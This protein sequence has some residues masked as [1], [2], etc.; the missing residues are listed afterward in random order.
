MH[1]NCRVMV[2]GAGSGV[3][4]G[5]IKSLKK[6]KLPITII[7]ADISKM[8]AGLYVADEAAIIPKVEDSDALNQMIHLINSKN[9]DFVMIGS[10]FDLLFFSNNKEKI[11]AETKAIVFVADSETVQIADD[12]W[13]TTE[14]LK[15]NDLPYAQAYLP[16][17]IEDAI[18]HL[19]KWSYPIILKARTGTSS[20]H[21][22][23]INNQKDLEEI[24]NSVPSPM[25]QKLIDMPS[26][27]L[28][29]EYTCSVF[30]LNDESLVGPFTAKRTVRSGTS[31]H[32]E[33]DEYKQIHELLI[34]LGGLLNF[35]GSLNVQLM[36]TNIG[37][38]PFEINSRFSG[39]TA[40]R[41]HFGFNEPEMALLSYLYQEDV[42]NPTI[43][44][45]V[46]MRYHEEVFIDDTDSDKLNPNDN[47]G[48]VSRWF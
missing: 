30:K 1:K 14:F 47:K 21:V 28:G 15:N 32:I 13:L 39:T 41:A 24:Y 9:I 48:K 7:A 3:G 4:Q 25:L 18:N 29:T 43:K 46:A 33:V 16:T 17:S 11:E 45:G 5:I 19:S 27:E 40:V 38:I 44:K 22:H 2:T 36:L 20:R 26:N 6:S 23:I 31:W 34:K 37:P 42:K 12:K 35:I 8:N 10:E